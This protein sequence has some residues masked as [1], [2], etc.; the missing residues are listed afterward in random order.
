MSF[1]VR[2]R[3]RTKKRPIPQ[4]RLELLESRDLLSKLQA[5]VLALVPN[6]AVTATASQS[7]NWS[8]PNTWQN[9]QAPAANDNVLIPSNVTVTVDTTTNAVHT[10]RVDGTLQFATNLNTNLLVDTLVVNT[11]ANLIIGTATTPIAAQNQATI[12]FTSN[13]PIDTTWDPYSLSRG[14][15]S[16][17]TVTICG[18]TTMPW[19]GLAGSASAGDITLTLA[20]LPTNWNASDV[21]VLGGTYAKVNQDE[22]LTVQS[23]QG[24]QITLSVPLAYDHTA[25]NGIPVYVTD[26]TRNVVFQSQ[27]QSTIGNRGHVMSLSN[28]VNVNNAEFLGLGRT[29]KSVVIN[30]P[31]LDSQG[32]LISGTG[33]NPRDRDP[34]VFYEDG[35][36]G[37]P[38]A[39]NGS[40]VVHSPGWGFVNHSSYANFAIDVAFDVNG[41]SFVSEA[42]DEI[43]SFSTNLAIH[44]VGTGDEEFYDPP[45]VAVQDWAHE[46]DGFWMQ[47]NGVSVTNN[48]AI[49]QLAAGYYYFFKPY[50]PP[51]AKR[52]PQRFAHKLP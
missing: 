13:G 28:L 1:F 52:G 38:G 9:Q 12:T 34:V 7:G 3:A 40:T 19:V 43:G 25:S 36:S 33:T 14:L 47:G 27:D 18:A 41:A 49:G 50:A 10:I 45:R 23:I 8:D 24:T 39:V 31:E 22:V 44:S 32:H 42:G 11:T 26:A 20:T 5:P 6:S 29:N 37:N 35:T 2:R 16:L 30:D 46:G 51:G 21:I 15:L 17:G 48:I 4:L